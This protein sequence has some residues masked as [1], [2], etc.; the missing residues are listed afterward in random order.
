MTGQGY[1][2]LGNA[3]HQ[4]AVAHND[5]SIMIA[6]I[7]AVSGGNNL[8]GQSHT[9]GGRNALSQR[10]GGDVYTGKV[11]VFRVAGGFGSELAEIA[12]VVNINIF[13]A[14]QIKQRIQQ[15]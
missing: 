4:A 15:A 11:A 14:Q 10:T 13:V 1:C 5:I 2:L 9:D 6:D 12:Q 7:G 3:F 8:L